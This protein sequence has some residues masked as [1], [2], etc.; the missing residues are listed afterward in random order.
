MGS[1]RC[2]VGLVYDSD[3]LDFILAIPVLAALSER[4]AGVIALLFLLAISQRTLLIC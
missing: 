2:Q 4:D 1:W 3:P